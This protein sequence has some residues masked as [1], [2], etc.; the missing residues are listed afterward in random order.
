MRRSVQDRIKRICRIGQV[1]PLLWAALVAPIPSLPVPELRPF[2]GL[3][4]DLAAVGDLGSVLCPPYDVISDAERERLAERDPHNAVRLELPDSYESAALLLDQ[5]QA[6]GVLTRDDRPMLY[7]YEQRYT[8]AGIERVARSFFCRLRLE[9]YSQG[10]V[11]RHEHTMGAAKEDR[12][13]LLTHT[14]VNLSPILLMYD[15]GDGGAASA[16]LL[17]ALTSTPPAA[18]AAGPDGVEQRLW[19]VDPDEFPQANDL[20]GLAAARPIYIA[21]GH[22]RYETALRYAGQPDAPAAAT[23]VLALMYDASS[24]GLALRPWHRII[25]G[26]VDMAAAVAA[27][28]D[29]FFAMPFQEA[30]ELLEYLQ[31]Y[32]PAQPAGTMGMWMRGGGILLA[33][34][35]EPT[36]STLDVDIL[37]DT[38]P[39]M[40]GST[41]AELAANGRLTYTADALE[42][43]AAVN[44]SRADVAFLLRPTPVEAVLSVARAGGVMPHKST[45]FHPKAATGLVFNPLRD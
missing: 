13:Q 28:Y 21:D 1:S 29:Q 25:A 45:Y 34:T 35:Q 20:L 8:L 17:D 43:I 41:G 15:D 27:A 16:R 24:G 44:E 7:V 18:R 9:D 23:F 26:P 12:F 42:A 3:R 39:A 4:F 11:L 5:W 32:E 14:R 37:S 30:A 2:R 19:M 10:G 38:L 31:A 36:A 40:I 33:G 6:D 22:H